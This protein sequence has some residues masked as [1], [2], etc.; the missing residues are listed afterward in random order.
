MAVAP[1]IALM[2]FFYLRDRY[3]KE[4]IWPV[5]IAFVLGAF[6]TLPAS[7]TSYFV[8]RITGWFQP[9]ARLFNV[10][11][12]AFIVAGLVEEIWKFL[13]VRFY[14]YH[15]PEFDDPY[16]GIIY[17]TAVALGFAT[18]ENILYVFNP[19]LIGGW[20]VGVLRAFMAVPSHAFY[21]V[22]M[23]YFLGEA[24]FTRSDTEA[25][26]LALVGLFLAILAHGLYDFIVIALP[27]RPLLL[28]SLVIFSVLVWVVF[29]EATRRQS[30]K[31]AYRVKELVELARQQREEKE[32]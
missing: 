18:L 10:F 14:C 24:K 21:G 16:D 6:V 5:F 27:Y 12:T 7:A 8:Q 15:R 9:S 17:A 30:E 1:S 20:R 2:L 25:N 11:L 4:P 22:L 32:E 26:L 28:G 19:S 3:K 13:I 29:F 31:S 23:G